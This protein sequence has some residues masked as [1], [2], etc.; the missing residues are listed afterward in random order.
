MKFTIHDR[1]LQRELGERRGY[2][3]IRGL[4]GDSYFVNNLD[5][6]NEL[7]GHSGPVNALRQ[8]MNLNNRIA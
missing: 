2:G 4:Y 7:K 6:V 5:I 8:V 1:L 3:G